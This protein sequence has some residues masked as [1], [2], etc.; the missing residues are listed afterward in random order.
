MSYGHTA[1]MARNRATMA[2]DAFYDFRVSLHRGLR[3][4]RR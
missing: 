3:Q 1:T 4:R 2:V